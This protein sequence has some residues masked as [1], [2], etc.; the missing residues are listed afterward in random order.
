MVWI[1]KS[2]K[3]EDLKECLVKLDMDKTVELVRSLLKEGA[4][5]LS[6]LN[7]LREGLDEVGKRYERGEYF[8]S[9]LIIAGD[10][11]KQ[12]LSLVRPKL[13]NKKEKP[14][15]KIVA[16]TV[17][18]DLHDIGKNIFLML[19]EASGF[20]VIDL[21]VDVPAEKFIE[22]A[23]LYKPSIIA[24]SALLTV[25]MPYMS[26]VIEALKREKLR[27]NIKV[28]I[29]GAPITKKFGEDIG[30]DYA[31]ETA[32]EG[33]EICKKWVKQSEISS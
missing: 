14:L 5:P 16:G 27:E 24:M 8:L 21:G 32:V 13:K 7:A 33:I 10:L 31:A 23:R 9:E 18:G 11:M 4:D 20:E 3:L 25:T 28:I 6:I 1:L 12:I 29:G 2:A 15:G 22:A 30:A 19:A 17:K 26:E